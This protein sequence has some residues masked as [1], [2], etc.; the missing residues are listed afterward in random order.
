[1]TRPKVHLTPDAGWMNDPHG[2]FFLDGRYHLFYQRVPQSV[3]WRHDVHWGY[4]TSDDLLHWRL[5]PDALAPGDGDEG[6]W[7][8][9][10]V[11]GDDGRP[12]I[13]YT[14]VAAPDRHLGRIRIARQDPATGEWVK[15]EIIAESMTPDTRMFRDPMIFRDGDTWRMLVGSGTAEGV[16]G[17]QLFRS[18]NLDEW[19]YDGWL[20]QRSTDARDPW[21][22]A[23]W[24]CPQIL[25]H[26]G[27]DGGDVLVV[28]VW[29]DKEPNDQGPNGVAAASGRLVGETFSAKSWR[30]LSG[31]HHFAATSFT[32]PAGRACLIFWIW[33][34][35]D[36]GTWAG[37]LSIPYVVTTASDDVRLSPH[38][39]VSAARLPCEGLPGLSLDI[40][41]THEPGAELAL[42]GSDGR[43]RAM[44]KA[45]DGRILVKISGQ[46]DPIEVLHT[47]PRLRVIVDAQVLEVVADGGL[48]GLPLDVPDGGFVP[49]A[50]GPGALDWWHL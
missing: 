28:S 23:G 32:D 34:I 49:I 7:S 21:T 41:W 43:K 9:C 14:S 44:L 6:C 11:V 47:S 18:T 22:G 16:A 19:E 38:P 5:E 13:F 46:A 1:M 25:R 17:A 20:A 37:A 40:E 31:H 29:D 15:G 4:A 2:V 42:A 39:A 27:G 10:A 3:E 36:H 33:D 48:V 35:H 8:G 24:E 26:V 50:E 45:G 30:V 12:V